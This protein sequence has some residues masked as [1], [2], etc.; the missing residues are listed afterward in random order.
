MEECNICLTCPSNSKW[1]VL[2]C[3]HKMCFSCFLKLQKNTCPYC[4]LP[5]NYT[6]KEQSLKYNISYTPPQLN[7]IT[8]IVNSFNQL[9]ID[10]NY[11]IPYSRINR[12]RYRKKRKNLTEEEIKEKRINIKERCKRKWINKEN[13]LKKWYDIVI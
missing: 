1:K 10:N 5:F 9:N 4:R 2:S 6:K 11:N 3:N 7:N 13:R 8:N 12:N